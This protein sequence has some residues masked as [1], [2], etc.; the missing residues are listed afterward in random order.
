MT[1]RLSVFKSAFVWLAGAALAPDATAASEAKRVLAEISH[2]GAAKVVARTRAGSGQAW[3]RITRG[4]ETGRA[5]WLEVAKAIKPGVDASSAEE[6]SFAVASAL[7]RNAAAVLK[8][9]GA[10]FPLDRVCAVPL[11]EPTEAQVRAWTR[12]ALAALAKVDD[13]S[14]AEASKACKAS[15][16]GAK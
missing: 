8:M 10:D 5:D 9:T 2:D 14:L 1:R 15:L 12:A 6:L 16:T 7:K 3:L 4:V 13:P 11:I